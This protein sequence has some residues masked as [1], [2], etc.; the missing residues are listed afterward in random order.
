ML[1]EI[2]WHIDIEPRCNPDSMQ[3]SLLLRL[4]CRVNGKAVK[5]EGFE[6]HAAFGHA[7]AQDCAVLGSDQA[8][9]CGS[10]SELSLVP[11]GPL[12]DHRAFLG[13]EKVHAHVRGAPLS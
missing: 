11:A 5:E 2:S 9:F 4:L 8:A 3:M 7:A 12:A 6:M 13:S 1:Q 10:A